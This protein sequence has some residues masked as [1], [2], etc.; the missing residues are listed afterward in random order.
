MATGGGDFER[1][2]GLLL[3]FDLTEIDVVTPC[4]LEHLREIDRASLQRAQFL[5]EFECLAQGLN[6]ENLHTLS[7]HRRFGRVLTRQD[8]SSEMLGAG[9]NRA[10]QC[11]LDSF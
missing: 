1:P 2:L 6:A 9:Q 11:A 8:D 4:A 10:R 5:E 7:D 3:S